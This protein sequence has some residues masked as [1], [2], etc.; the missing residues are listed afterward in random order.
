MQKT[1][2]LHTTQWYVIGRCSVFAAL[3]GMQVVCRVFDAYV[4]TKCSR[5]TSMLC[6]SVHR[7]PRCYQKLM[8][9]GGCVSGFFV[10]GL[11]WVGCVHEF[12]CCVWWCVQVCAC[13]FKID[14]GWWVCSLIFVVVYVLWWCGCFQ[15]LCGVGVCARCVALS[16]VVVVVFVQVCSRCVFPVCVH[17]VC[18]HVCGGADIE[19]RNSLLDQ[20][21]NWNTSRQKQKKVYTCVRAFRWTQMI[22]QTDTAKGTHMLSE[23]LHIKHFFFFKKKCST[24]MKNQTSTVKKHTYCSHKTVSRINID[25]KHI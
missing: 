10:C 5:V 23:P 6:V 13:V 4:L 7:G 8:W 15:K 3:S 9:R 2:H 21:A 20:H 17:G 19:A 16:F 22:N 11:M 12:L 25:P 18:V 24:P 1:Y 14:V